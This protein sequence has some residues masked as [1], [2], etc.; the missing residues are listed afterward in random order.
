MTKMLAG[1]V[2]LSGLWVKRQVTLCTG[3][4]SGAVAV[5]VCVLTHHNPSGVFCHDFLAERS[6]Q[7]LVSI[8][9]WPCAATA[10]VVSALIVTA[11]PVSSPF[12]VG[13]GR[14]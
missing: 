9:S 8:C 7:I 6:A 12:L 5:R 10:A 4:G 1:P 3:A 11:G 14:L 13:R 2:D